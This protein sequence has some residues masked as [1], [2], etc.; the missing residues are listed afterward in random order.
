MSATKGEHTQCGEEQPKA[1]PNSH[2]ESLQ[3]ESDGLGASK[4]PQPPSG[5][6][7]R[8]SVQGVSGVGLKTFSRWAE[9]VGAAV[10]LFT[11]PKRCIA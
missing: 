8:P 10:T 9:L 11:V 3:Y 2:D 6:I 4:S 5:S 7:P 1:K